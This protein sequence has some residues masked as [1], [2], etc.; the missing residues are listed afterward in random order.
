MYFALIQKVCVIAL[1]RAAE[2][3]YTMREIAQILPS[4]LVDLFVDGAASDEAIQI[5]C[6]CLPVPSNT[7]YGLSLRLVVLV[8]SPCEQRRNEDR[9]IGYRQ[10]PKCHELVLYVDEWMRLTLHLHSRL[11]GSTE[12]CATWNWGSGSLAE[13][14]SAG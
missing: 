13:P 6:F 9:M 5:C 2:F 4:T 10:V 14:C 8:L 11:Q 12:G 3:L 7:A 1:G